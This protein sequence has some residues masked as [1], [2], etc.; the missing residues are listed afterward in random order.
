MCS[1]YLFSMVLKMLIS[2]KCYMNSEAEGLERF[3]LWCQVVSDKSRNN[4]TI[5]TQLL[6]SVFTNNIGNIR[7]AL[8]IKRI[9]DQWDNILQH[10]LIFYSTFYLFLHLFTWSQN[11]KEFI[12]YDLQSYLFTQLQVLLCPQ[13]VSLYVFLQKISFFS[14]FNYSTLLKKSEKMNVYKAPFL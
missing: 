9:D 5:A 11:S 1:I 8:L 13:Q 6:Q 2:K 14:F 10:F 12:I 4:V 7:A 3:P